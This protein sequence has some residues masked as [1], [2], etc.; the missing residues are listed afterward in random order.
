[1]EKV[2]KRRR[3]GGYHLPKGLPTALA[4]QQKGGESGQAISSHFLSLVDIKY[5]TQDDVLPWQQADNLNLVNSM[6]NV[7]LSEDRQKEVCPY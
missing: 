1:M 5:K 2:I 7:S 4:P 6:R 3:T